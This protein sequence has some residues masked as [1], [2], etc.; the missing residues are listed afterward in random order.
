MGHT[1]DALRS[2]NSASLAPRPASERQM[3]L[4]AERCVSEVVSQKT[5]ERPRLSWV[6]ENCKN[7]EKAASRATVLPI[8]R[9]KLRARAATVDKTSQIP[10]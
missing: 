2:R 5:T 7:G 1:L 10:T 8:R 3:R 6:V 9:A 4:D